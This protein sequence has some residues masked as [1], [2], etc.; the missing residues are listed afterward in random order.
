MSKAWMPLYIG[1]YQ[2]DTQHLDAELHGIYLLLIMHYWQ[3]GALPED[4][5]ALARIACTSSARWRRAR[6]VIRAFFSE[7]WRH[8]RIERELAKADRSYQR[9][10]QAGQKGAKVRAMLKQCSSNAQ[11]M[12][13]QSQSQ[14]ASLLPSQEGDCPQEG[15]E[16]GARVVSL[17]PARRS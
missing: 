15:V 6:P 7:G 16:L 11:A 13:M 4:D 1:D 5:A 14:G 9:R 12:N 10:A 17:A 2:A 8:A 3:Q